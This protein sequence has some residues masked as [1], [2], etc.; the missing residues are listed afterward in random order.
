MKKILSLSMLLMAFAF[1]GCNRQNNPQPAQP[2]PLPVDI[3]DYDMLMLDNGDLYF[4]NSK[5]AAMT[6]LEAEEDS[7]VNCLFTGDNKVYYSV[8]EGPKILLRCIDLEQPNPQPKQL[9]DWGVPYEECVT[10][11]YGEVS[12]LEYYKG[13][14]TLGLYHNFSWDGYW[15]ID[16]KL[17]NMETGEITDWTWE[18]EEE[19]LAMQSDDEEEQT[20]EN[21]HYISTA[22]E[23]RDYLMQM[24]E[25]YYMTDGNDG[26]Y[27]CLTDKID[28]ASYASSPEYYEGPEFEYISASP[29]NLKVLYMII[30][31]WGDFPHGILA[32]SSIDGKLQMPLED[33]DCTGFI[34]DWLDDG[35]LVYVGEEPVSP[36]DPDDDTSWH[37]RKHCIKRIYPDNHT[38]IIAHCGEFRLKQSL[39][40]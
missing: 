13:R 12:P 35:S 9:A 26:D 34:A 33:T 27:V 16:Q 11:T 30:V 36:D 17:Y 7:I 20:E 4:Y 24:D 8:V 29:D 3:A 14:N 22:Y 28:C 40:Q 19:W 15:F 32:V 38:E 39:L 2:N 18:W 21:Y 6:L 25:Q 31:E 37:Y 1:L 23:L 5:T 10:E